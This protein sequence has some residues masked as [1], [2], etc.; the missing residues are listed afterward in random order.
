MRSEAEEEDVSDED[1]RDAVAV[2]AE[3]QKTMK[4]PEKG[5]A[6]RAE[7]PEGVDTQ[8]GRLEGDDRG[9]QGQPGRLEALFRQLS[10]AQ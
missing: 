9:P 3:A 7:D 4:E 5:Q 1:A 8:P 2:Y 10:E 6:H